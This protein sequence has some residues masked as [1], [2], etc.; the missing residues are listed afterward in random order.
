MLRQALIAGRGHVDLAALKQELDQSPELIRVGRDVSTKEILATELY[1]IQTLNDGKDRCFSLA[2]RFLP[3]TQLGKDQREALEHVLR[4]S[5]QFAGFRGLA[6]TG[7]TSTLK[8][9][10]RALSESGKEV[11][12]CAPTAAATQVLRKDGFSS[13]KT[14]AKLLHEDKLIP[15]SVIVL[16]EAGLVGARDM[17]QLFEQVRAKNARLIFSGDTGQHSSVAQGDALRLLE[18]HSRYS[19]RELTTIRRQQVEEYR[20]VVEYAANERPKSL[21]TG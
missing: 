21:L 6:G 10:G 17:K 19:F 12:F 3:S 16:D 8:E 13:A 5:D 14:L 7:K 4:T 20:H 2:P 11:V 15:G 1:L 9:L 18:E